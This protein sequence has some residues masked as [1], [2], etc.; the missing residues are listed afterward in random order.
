M[1]ILSKDKVKPYWYTRYPYPTVDGSFIQNWL[2]NGWSFNRWLRELEILKEAGQ[3][4]LILAPTV[5]SNFG[6]NSRSIYP[7]QISGITLTPGHEMTLENCLKACQKL[8]MKLFLGLNDDS[9][10]WEMSEADAPWFVGEM[11]KGN[12]IAKELYV[13]YKTRYPETFYG[14]YWVFEISSMHLAKP[15]Y[16]EY[17]A[18]AINIQ[19]DFLTNLD[20]SM[21]LMLCPYMVENVSSPE[22][23][24]LAW[25]NF[26]KQAHFRSGDILCPQDAVGA[27][28]LRLENFTHW[29]LA[30]KKA[31]KEVLGL[32]FW[33]DAETFRQEDW[34]STTLDRFIEQ[35]ELASDVV[36]NFISFAYCH[37]FSP[38]IVPRGYHQTYLDYLKTGKLKKKPVLPPTNAKGC[39]KNDEIVLSWDKQSLDEICGYLIYAHNHLQARLQP[40]PD[41]AL[42]FEL[43]SSYV[44]KKDLSSSKNYTLIAYDYAGNQAEPVCVTIE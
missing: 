16:Q 19:L 36:D 1:S 35:L 4:Y 40:K 31:C 23:T 3:N 5:S 15:L 26:L 42:R 29:F 10:W 25:S 44:L 30:L 2:V 39:Y 20:S 32:K 6:K 11:E 38:Q 7:S 34:T 22:E 27:G 43:P 17:L 41:P 18:K 9:H 21:P 37:Y 13:N 8:D 33:S 24:Y 28:W 14:W 12:A